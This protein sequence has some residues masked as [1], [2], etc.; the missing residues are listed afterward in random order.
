MAQIF[1]N[2]ILCGLRARSMQT[3]FAFAVV[4]V[5]VALLAGS[6]SARQPQ[7]VVLDVGLS[8]L[9]FSLVLL[10]I[11]WVQELITKEIDRRIVIF[12]L[13]YPISR[14]EYLVGRFLGILFLLA[15]A[16]VIMALLLVV[17]VPLAGGGYEQSVPVQLAAQYWATIAAIWLDVAVVT[18]FTLWVATFSTVSVLPLAVGMAFA[19]CTRS[20]GVVLQYLLAGA[21]GDKAIEANYRPVLEIAQWVLPDLSRL[22]WRAWPMYGE[23]PP[24]GVML[25]AV[26]MALCY[27]FVM[28]SLAVRGFSKREFA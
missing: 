16:T 20:L 7:T 18:A 25:W 3:A 21:D 5:S 2:T 26:L 15:L 19:V 1:F 8:C 11:V 6:F 27:L 28:L 17:F 13:T 22:D 4:L 24:P 14:A 23:A 9:R 10:A 12:A